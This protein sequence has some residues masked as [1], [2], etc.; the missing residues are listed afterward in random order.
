M[1]LLITTKL[2]QRDFKIMNKIGISTYIHRAALFW[3]FRFKQKF[4]SKYFPYTPSRIEE[5]V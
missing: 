5:S 1:L 3:N 2:L 4:Y